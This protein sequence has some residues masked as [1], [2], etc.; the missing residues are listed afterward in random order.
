M[1]RYF[2][3]AVC[4]LAVIASASGANAYYPY[5][6]IASS[7]NF[8]YGYA[9]NQISRGRAEAGAIRVCQAHTGHGCAVR[10]WFSGGGVCGAL[11]RHG[12]FLGWGVGRGLAAARV[13]ALRASRGGVV[14]ANA[15]N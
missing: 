14:F 5:G 13:S 2:I 3:A 10:V 6:A 7:A 8:G 1:R 12:N 9:V 4:A 11:A 15:C